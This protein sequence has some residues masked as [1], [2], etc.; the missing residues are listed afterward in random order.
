MPRDTKTPWLKLKHNSS[1]DDL[2]KACKDIHKLKQGATWWS[3]C[4]AYC[5]FTRA[6]PPH[7]RGSEGRGPDC[8]AQEAAVQ[9]HESVPDG[10]QA[11]DGDH[12]VQ[13]PLEASQDVAQ[14]G[15]RQRL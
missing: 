2:V 3:L 13:L 6:H 14:E 4:K 7:V 10:Q 1:I 8:F 11:R 9:E 5:R 15:R 12:C